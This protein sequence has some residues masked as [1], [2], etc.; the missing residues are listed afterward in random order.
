MLAEKINYEADKNQN[1][2]QISL[3]ELI[4]ALA[5]AFDLAESS[6]R[7]HSLRTAYIASRLA[8]VMQMSGQE[9]ENIYFASLLHD[10]IPPE[11]SFDQ[12]LIFDILANLPL[13]P[14][15]GV[16]V[17]KL[18]QYK[19]ANRHQRLYLDQLDLQPRI[20]Y[21]AEY[22]EDM[23]CSGFKNEKLLRRTLFSWVDGTVNAADPKIAA[24]LHECMTEEAFW[25]DIKENRIYHA[26]RRIAPDSRQQLDIDDV[27]KVSCSFSL[28]IDRKNP[29]TGRHSQ[30]VGIIAGSLAQLYGLHGGTVRK[31]SIAGY[32]HDL[33]KLAVSE[34]ILNKSG[35]LTEE[36]KQIIKAHPY[37]SYAV[38]S[39]IKGFADIARWA[40]NHHERMD[41]SGYPWGRV[42]LTV[43]D[44]IIAVADVYEA[45]T[46]DRPY[47]SALSSAE[48]LK[49]IN[50]QARR[51]EIMPEACDL[52]NTSVGNRLI[53][54]F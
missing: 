37:D 12:R 1:T 48:A 34:Q 35:S 10:L 21:L 22:F 52:L 24:A 33:G 18:W 14:Q 27:E 54:V 30:R 13:M 26:I 41:G 17:A 6:E 47:R 23:Y 3:N 5:A 20:I 2:M 46:A 28:L 8:T 11:S 51:G 42:D 50:I 19:Q 16:Q 7:K 36:E 45:L 9:V 32:L 25:Q 44:Q 4:T 40:G 43:E 49:F 53:K 31:I 15:V 39:E 29:Y 38:L